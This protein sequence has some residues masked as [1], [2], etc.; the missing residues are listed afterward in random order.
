MEPAELDEGWEDGYAVVA[1]GEC[2]EVLG[3]MCE[4]WAV[5][6]RVMGGVWVVTGVAVEV[7]EVMGG[8]Y[9]MGLG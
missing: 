6:E 8:G 7:W 3:E 9:V 4:V 2:Q 1:A 5:M